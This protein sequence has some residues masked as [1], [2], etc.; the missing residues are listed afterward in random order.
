MFEHISQRLQRTLSMMRGVVRVDEASLGE[1]LRDLRMALLEADV[2]FGVVKDF[3]A[4]V[5]ERAQG[6]EVLDSLSPGQ[7]VVKIVHEEM[8]KLLG[9]ARVSLRLEGATPHVVMLVGLQ[10]AGKTTTAAKLGHRLRCSGH[11]P[12]LASVDVHRPAAREQLAQ[13][14]TSAS[15][16]AFEGDGDDPVDLARQAVEAA[17]LNGRDVVVLDTA[18]R[19]HLDGTM[20]DEAAALVE[21][22]NPGDVVYVADS[23]AG[24]DA[25]NTV[26][27]FGG[28]LPLTGT[29]L[30]KLDGDARGGVAMSI[31]AVTGLP[32]LYVGVGER[33]E[34]LEPFHPDRIASRILGMGDILTLIEKAQDA[35]DVEKT[36]D[37]EK[38]LREA[39]FTFEDFR[40]QMRQMNK[41]GSIS[42]LFEMLPMG[43]GIDSKVLAPAEDDMRRFS[44]IID[45]MTA[46]ERCHPQ[47]IDG[48][49]RRRIAKG[50]GTRV[51]DVNQLLKQFNTARKLM[52]K[53]GRQRGNP[54]DMMRSAGFGP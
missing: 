54:L 39:T 43:R 41:I 37:M 25:V 26:S 11:S 4:V 24:Q 12:L 32:I 9:G 28:R 33:F 53:L 50:S 27:V 35:V 23:L 48:S 13:M 46:E 51:Q 30:T 7:Q 8:V 17:R 47:T 49:R 16:Q 31:V 34:D 10:G 5:G 2:N 18:G 21:A 15:L 29:V 44:A 38:R 36:A 1:A 45:S 52:R 20:M 42:K 3:L 14:A 6:Q 22:L 19:L 40:E